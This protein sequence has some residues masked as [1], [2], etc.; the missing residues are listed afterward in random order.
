M[1]LKV[2]NSFTRQKEDLVTLQPGEVKMYVCGPN[3]YGPA[4]VGHAMSYVIFDTIRRYLEYRGYHVRHVQNF[5]DIEDRI[6][7]TARAQGTTVQQLADKYI[8]RFYAEMDGLNVLRAHAHPRATEVIPKI[9]EIVQGLIAK[10]HAYEVDGDVYFRVTSFPAYG[11]LSRRTL[12]QMEAGARVEVDERKEHPMDFALWKAAKEGEP[13]WD[14]PWGKGR[15]GWHIECSAM[16]MQFLGEQLDIHGGG[17][18]VVFPHHENEIA[19][20]EAYTGK[21]PFV[22]YWIHNALLRLREDEEKMTRHLGNIV[23]VQE[24]LQKYSADGIRLFLLSSHYRSPLTWKDSSVRAAEQGVERLRAALKGY[25]RGPEKSPGDPL[26]QQ[27]EAARQDFIVAMDDDFNSPRAMA[28][29]YDLARVINQARDSGMTAESLAYAQGILYEL[30]QV[31]GLTMKGLAGPTEAEPFISLLADVRNQLRAAKQWALAD[32]IRDQLAARGV[33][34]EDGP[35][36]TT[37][38]YTTVKA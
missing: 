10:G 1:A 34:L 37:W 13:A 3:L 7:E 30:T 20:S 35:E 32:Q 28:Q 23:S 5:T 22:R 29:V 11:Q 2:H 25:A 9:I 27:A 38:K 4:H 19:Q 26:S 33:V 36:G 31:L 17:H 14:S 12:D 21:S 8:A 15:P 16:S 18:D 6:I 24:A